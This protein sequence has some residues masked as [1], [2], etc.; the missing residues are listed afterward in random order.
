MKKYDIAIIGAGPAGY[1][2]AIRAGKLGF[3]TVIF[4]AEKLGGVCLNHGCIPSKTLIKTA[5]VLNDVKKADSF[6]ISLKADEISIDCKKLMKRKDKIIRQLNRGVGGLLKAA[7]VEV[8]EAFANVKSNTELEA[9]GEIYQFKHLIIATG[10]SDSVPNFPNI[11]KFIES[12]FVINSKTALNLDKIPETMLIYGSG[13]IAT[14]FACMYNAFGT[15]V[16]YLL[17]TKDKIDEKVDKEIDA[18]MQKSLKKSGIQ[19][20]KD[21][22]I[23]NIGE[24]LVKF[25]A[26]SKEQEISIEKV[27]I[28]D[29]RVSNLKGLEKL[30]LK[31]KKGRIETD[32]YL[33]TSVKNVYAIGDV[34]GNTMLAHGASAEAIAL[35]E[36]LK[37]NQMKRYVNPENV[38]VCYYTIPEIASVGITEEEAKTR[39]ID[40][41]TC[42]FNIS[43]NGKAMTE[44]ESVGFVKL[45]YDKKLREFLGMHILAPNATELISEGVIAKELEACIDNFSLAVHPHPTISEMVMEAAHGACDRKIHG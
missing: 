8:V 28:C 35:V 31:L 17:N 3:K 41:G 25:T 1:V 34:N 39:N 36:S 30:N 16:T 15:K 12:N 4:E 22:K 44:N 18:E 5:K 6:G 45:I 42:K 24:N 20:I 38:P 43:A 11:E 10:S 33:A 7:K 23:T 26:E 14:E 13:I 19:I 9:N 29:T 40:V 2:A 32:K 21:A 37:D 27:L